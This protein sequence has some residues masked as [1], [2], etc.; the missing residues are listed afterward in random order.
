MNKDIKYILMSEADIAEA[1]ERI[2]EQINEAFNGEPLLAVI[3]L[4]G[5]V[6]FAADLIRKLNMPV[7]VDF[8]KVSSYGDTHISTG[9]VRIDLD[10]KDDL[11][12][13][14]VLIIEDIVDSGNTLFKL[15]AMLQARN[16]KCIKICTLLDKPE[17]REVPVKVDYV[18][19]V[20]P[21]EFVVGY[22]LD[23]S[24]NYRNLPYIGVLDEKVYAQ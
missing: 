15:K 22:G 4:K 20:I 5:S 3:I 7:E 2:A 8:M 14:N 11:T 1:V 16:A 9:A 21:N 12:D 19:K 17:R 10:T 23:Y 18:G 13:N 6:F 24:E